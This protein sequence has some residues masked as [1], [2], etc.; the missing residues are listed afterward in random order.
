[1]NVT[2]HCKLFFFQAVAQFQTQSKL[3][4]YDNDGDQ[5][6]ISTEMLRFIF[7]LFFPAYTVSLVYQLPRCTTLSIR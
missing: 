2:F 4:L 7:K 3:M 6:D 5:G 1:M